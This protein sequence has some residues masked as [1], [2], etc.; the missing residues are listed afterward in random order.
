MLKGELAKQGYDWWWHSFTG[1]AADT[2]EEKSFFVEFF[3][4]QPRTGRRGT[5][6]W[7]AGAESGG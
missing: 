4:L 2:G 6:L 5:S 7:S 1:H 3:Y